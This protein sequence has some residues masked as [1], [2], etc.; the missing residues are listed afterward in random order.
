MLSL[1][2]AAKK[3]IINTEDYNIKIYTDS[4]DT[5]SIDTFNDCFQVLSNIAN[6][7]YIKYSDDEIAKDLDNV[8]NRIKVLLDSNNI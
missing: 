6:K 5:K 8:S 3:D 2:L 1:V 7:I 4:Y